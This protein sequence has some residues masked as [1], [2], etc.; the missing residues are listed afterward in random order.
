VSWALKVSSISAP[1]GLLVSTRTV[2]STIKTCVRA[3]PSCRQEKAGQGRAGQGWA[4]QGGA[5]RGRV[6]QSFS[7]TTTVQLSY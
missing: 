3:A 1:G 4:G 6:G 5:R 2:V 7:E